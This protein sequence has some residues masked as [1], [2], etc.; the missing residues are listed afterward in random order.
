M[1]Q[2]VQQRWEGFLNPDVLRPLLIS[3]AIY[4][5]GYESLKDS[6]I[7]RVRGFYSCGFDNSGDKIA[8]EYQ[9]KVLSRNKSPLYASLDWLKTEAQAIDNADLAA[10]ERVKHCR[11]TLSHKLF[12]VL[13]SDGLPPDFEACFHDMVAMLCK[14][15]K[16]WIINVEIPTDPDFDDKDVDLNGIMPGRSIALQMLCEI[17]LGDPQT[18]R[19]YY[20]G[21]KKK[22]MTNPPPRA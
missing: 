11:N 12:T 7:T 13:G 5:A 1:D 14:I 15:E 3:A 21:F 9:I 22:V 17:A 16:W 4:I 20:E 10:F 19:F 6:I 8:P 2:K 18:A